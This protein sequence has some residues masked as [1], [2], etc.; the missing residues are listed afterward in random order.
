MWVQ[1]DV[2][3]ADSTGTSGEPMVVSTQGLSYQE[4]L[5]LC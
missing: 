3:T 2:A 4:I 1:Q 5:E